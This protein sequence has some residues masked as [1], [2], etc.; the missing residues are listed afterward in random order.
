[1]ERG[2]EALRLAALPREAFEA[3]L[4]ERSAGVLGRLRL[5]TRLGLHARDGGDGGVARGGRHAQQVAVRRV[6]EVQSL[7]AGC[8][9]DLVA[10]LNGL[11]ELV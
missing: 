6:E 2:A 8:T 5:A 11:Y 1:M 4:N 7:G 10:L 3:A 9:V